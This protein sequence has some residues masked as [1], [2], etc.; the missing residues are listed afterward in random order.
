MLKAIQRWLTVRFVAPYVVSRGLYVSQFARPG[1]PSCV[2]NL[3]NDEFDRILIRRIHR[4]VKHGYP[5]L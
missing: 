5:A 1:G 2:M 4:M 3:S